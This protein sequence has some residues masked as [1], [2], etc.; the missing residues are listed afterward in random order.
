MPTFARDCK[1]KNVNNM[2]PN[3]L[4]CVNETRRN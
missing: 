3:R 4:F 2:L 1:T